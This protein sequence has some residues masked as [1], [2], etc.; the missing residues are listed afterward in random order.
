MKR[1]IILT[2]FVFLA[3]CSTHVIPIS[4]DRL[5]PHQ[6]PVAVFRSE[7]EAPAGYRVVAALTHYDW[8]KYQRL[9]IEDAIPILQENARSQGANGIIIDGCEAVY[10]GIISRGIDV[11]ARA[12]LIKNSSNVYQNV[13]Q[14]IK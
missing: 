13:Y 4:K 2:L 6:G 3:S 5:T 9:S 1:C 10:S 14:D 11:K 7:S 12:I 8:G